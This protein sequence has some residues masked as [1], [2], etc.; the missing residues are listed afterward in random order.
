[1]FGF[2]HIFFPQVTPEIAE[3]AAKSYPTPEKEHVFQISPRMD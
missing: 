3:A 1:L 2:Y